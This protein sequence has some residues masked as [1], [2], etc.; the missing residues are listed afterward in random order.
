MNADGTGSQ[1]LRP[2]N[3]WLIDTL[4]VPAS[5]HDAK[6]RF[7]HLNPA[8]ERACGYPKEEFLGRHFTYPVPVAEHQRL[9]L[10][11]GR[12]VDRCEPAEFETVFVDAAGRLRS[13]RAQ[14]LPLREGEGVVGVI[15]LA[16]DVRYVAGSA[17]ASAMGPRLTSRQQEILELIAAGLSP[18]EIA[19]HLFLSTVTVRNHL[20]RLYKQLRVHNALEAV[21]T[22]RRLGLLTASPLGPS[23]TDGLPG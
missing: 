23:Q 17:S 7:V 6:G 1:G 2:A 10:L 4:A 11:F 14:Y 13:S 3:L 12:A 19:S 20:R 9:E 15:I 18:A 5:L 8:A 21:A 16:F 22:A